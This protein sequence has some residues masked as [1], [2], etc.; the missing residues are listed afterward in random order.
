MKP[1]F[2]F[3]L[4]IFLIG[5]L[6]LPCQQAWAQ[7]S[8]ADTTNV[9]S[10]DT[11][12]VAFL[13]SDGTIRVNALHDAIIADTGANASIRKSLTRVYKLKLNGTYYE[14]DQI[15][16]NGWPLT[17]VADKSSGADYPPEL[18]MNALRPDGSASSVTLSSG[19]MLNSG[20]DV[21]LR[22]LFIS[23][24]N[25]DNGGQTVYEPVFFSANNAK[26]IIDGCILEQSNFSLIVLNGKNCNT[27]IVNNRFRNLEENPPTQQWTGRGISIW[28]DQDTVVM[29]N[30]TFFN[31]GMCVFQMEGGSANYLRFNHNTVANLGR[32]IVSNSGDWWQSA[33]FANN[34]IINGWWEGEG[35]NAND[36]LAPS[37]DPRMT[38][39][40]LFNVAVLPTSYG[41]EQSRRVVITNEYAY[42]DPLIIAK[43]GT[44]DTIARAWFV[45]PVSKADYLNKYSVSS[46]NGH[47][48]V[49]DTTWLT[50][51]PQ[52]MV[53]YL[54]DANWDQV[55]TTA[56]IPVN[57]LSTPS[58]MVDSMW[59]MITEIRA[60]G[61]MYTT[62]FYHPSTFGFEYWPLPENFAYTDA[63]LMTAG[64][65]GL[66]IGDLNWFPTQKAT[67]LANQ[68]HYVA[69]IED[70]AGKVPI[71]SVKDKIEAESGGVG[72]TSTIKQNQG[73]IYWTYGN[74]GQV[75]WTFNVPTGKA[76]IYNTKWEVNLFGQGGSQG[77][78]LKING[79][80]INDKALGWGA[81]PFSNAAEGTPQVP[82]SGLPASA[83]A[84][85]EL[86][87]SN[88]VTPAAFT[89]AAGTNTVGV[90][91]GGWNSLE[92]AEIDLAPATG[93]TGTDTI[94][95]I[96]ANGVSTNAPAS[97]VGIVWVASGFK[98]VNLGT[99]G[100][101]TI[102]ATVAIADNYRLNFVGQNISGSNQTLTVS[103]GGTVLG[104]A[105]LPSAT[106]NGV[107][108]STGNTGVTTA[109]ELTAGTHKFVLSGANVNIDYVQLIKEDAPPAGVKSKSL[110]PN[111]F[112]LEQNYPNPFNPTT[113]I[114]FS[115]AKASNVKLFVYNILGQRV[116]TLIDSRV[117]SAGSQFVTFDASRFASGVYFYRLEAGSFTAVKKMLLLK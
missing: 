66:P 53:N 10:G 94:K 30:N 109:F 56:N 67:F 51:L 34:L 107:T 90:Y 111:I 52:G 61:V 55:A 3:S 58:K 54:Y 22:N 63:T 70:L 23:G 71:D 84:W 33:F 17:I 8:A 114:N 13:H 26:N 11:M 50:S 16:N 44:P 105:V 89:L 4:F 1:L 87:T 68:A 91:A 47:M 7:L 92:F 32:G 45:D 96:G 76:G 78:V 31:V 101:D 116:A 57:T 102:S 73:F 46:G 100:T 108:D 25:A 5:L 65:D 72:G 95:N 35:Q 60:A 82:E 83:W 88:C 99:A 106:K 2:Y 18:Q 38:Y 75:E 97:A 79:A 74:V 81:M 12:M 117:M 37:R 115:L 42:L 49:G 103:E 93:S 24:R 28:V 77:M 43:Y 59:A 20:G 62:F 112:T 39:S 110:N 113:T 9:T 64:T 104:T 69:V 40:G 27:Y 86:D 48:Y 29:E 19:G 36:L 14:V 98:Y 80:Q 21:T 15:V 85:V 6:V 41:L